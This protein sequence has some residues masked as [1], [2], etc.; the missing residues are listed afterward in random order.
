MT[1]GQRIYEARRELGLSQRQLA[2]EEMT[3]N[4]LSALE[5]DTAN[6]SLATLQYLSKRLDKPVAWLLGEDV[7]SGAE[8]GRLTQARFSYAAGAWEQ[9][10]KLL[11]E[12]LEAFAR[13]GQLLRCLCLLEQA[14]QA[15]REDRLPYARQLLEQCEEEGL[16][17]LY[18]DLLRPRL[19]RL[20]G[21]PVDL[22]G[23]LLSNARIALSQGDHARAQAL[24]E[25]V[26]RRE[27]AWERLMGEALFGQKRYAESM[28]H[29]L[30]CGDD[31]SLSKRL[32]I[33]CRELGDYR[34]AYYY[35][36]RN[37]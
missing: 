8:I 15:I 9:C 18:F 35:A 34:R 31:A 2:G 25:A 36:T 27:E 23:G 32:E 10:L 20:M 21:R 28:E 24:L 16:D 19:D 37:R 12:P 26:S 14:E 29:Y 6:P 7:L 5:H 4:M 11:Q 17:S 1:L 3:R 22:D 13:E 30:R 33:C